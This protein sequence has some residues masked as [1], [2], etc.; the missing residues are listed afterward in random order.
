MV[1]QHIYCLCADL[2]LL[3]LQ[4]WTA[5]SVGTQIHYNYNNLYREAINCTHRHCMTLT[6]HYL[7]HL[8]C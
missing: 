4:E 8:L 1:S 7:E 6:L 2:R 5:S 3:W